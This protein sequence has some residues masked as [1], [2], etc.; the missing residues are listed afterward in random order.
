MIAFQMHDEQRAVL[1]GVPAPE[2][3]PGLVG[4]DAAQHGADEAEERGEADDAIDH[5]PQRLAQDG[6]TAGGPDF[7]RRPSP[8]AADR[9][10]TGCESSGVKTP[11]KM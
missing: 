4:P 1:L 5:F 8:A 11:R 3:A 9:R 6:W 10:P 7:A 2:P